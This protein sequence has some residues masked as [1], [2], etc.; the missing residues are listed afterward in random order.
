MSAQKFLGSFQSSLSLLFQAVQDGKE[1][2]VK[3]WLQFNK[4]RNRAHRTHDPD[5]HGLCPIHYAAK[6]NQ[7]KIMKLLCGK[8]G[9]AGIGIARVS[10]TT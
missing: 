8:E 2:I 1:E 7:P 10:S 5:K 4:S 3:C 9:K 6:F